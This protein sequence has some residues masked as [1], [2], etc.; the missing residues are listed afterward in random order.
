MIGSK[1][2]GLIFSDGAENYL[3][4]DWMASEFNIEVEKKGDLYVAYSKE[5]KNMLFF[6]SDVR[7]IYLA[8]LV[9]AEKESE[10]DA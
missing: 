10:E 9:M 7:I 4:I 2:D 5:T 8:L 1:S 3:L 6:S